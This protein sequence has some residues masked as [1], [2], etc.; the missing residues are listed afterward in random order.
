MFDFRAPD[1]LLSMYYDVKGE[2]MEPAFTRT[3]YRFCPG[4]AS[5]FSL[6]AGNELID[7]WKFSGNYIIGMRRSS[8][9]SILSSSP[10]LTSTFL[11]FL[12]KRIATPTANPMPAPIMAPPA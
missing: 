2:Q 5:G 8:A 10:G 12:A 3:I 4:K 9:S 11:P 1:A 7:L 6:Q